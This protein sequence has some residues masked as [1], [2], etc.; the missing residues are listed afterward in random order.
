MISVGGI[1]TALQSKFNAASARNAGHGVCVQPPRRPVSGGA[2]RGVGEGKASS[3]MART[4]IAEE[5]AGIRCW[6]VK[7]GTV[8]A[9]PRRWPAAALPLDRCVESG[10]ASGAAH[11]LQCLGRGQVGQALLEHPL[12]E[13]EGF[14]VQVLA[15]PGVRHDV[16]RGGRCTSTCST[17]STWQEGGAYGDRRGCAQGS[18]DGRTVHGP[19]AC[20]RPRNP[21][22]PLT[23]KTHNH[24]SLALSTAAAGSPQGSAPAGPA[25]A[26]CIVGGSGGRIRMSM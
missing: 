2:T 14:R 9:C 12:V 15:E 7:H 4:C 11:L 23:P 1:A 5:A 6:W 21:S 8:Q 10:C 26:R 18:T 24:P 16:L 17:C 20:S 25:T 22:T 19:S 3:T 13:G